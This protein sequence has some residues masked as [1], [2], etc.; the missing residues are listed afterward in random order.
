MSAISDPAAVHGA[1]VTSRDSTR[2]PLGVVEQVY[3]DVATGTPTWA[4]VNGRSLGHRCLVPL[5]AAV[6]AGSVLRVPFSAAELAWAP[7]HDPGRELTPA[8]ELDLDAYY[9][10]IRAPADL[11]AGSAA[12]TVTGESGPV[13]STGELGTVIR[14]EER[15][16]VG[17]RNQAV[18]VARLRKYVTTEVVTQTVPV[19]HEELVVDRHPVSAEDGSLPAGVELREEVRDVV[20]HAQQVVTAKETVPV[21]RI[22]LGTRTVVNEQSVTAEVLK[23]N[24]VLDDVDNTTI[25]T[26]EDEAV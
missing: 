3:C 5:S 24:V 21:E 2:T 9:A 13:A 4:L 16:H 6:L 18:G 17:V 11:N 25:G 12:N 23:E 8:D 14:S 19:T 15:L 22:R 20:L 26:R 7:H 1:E 10:G